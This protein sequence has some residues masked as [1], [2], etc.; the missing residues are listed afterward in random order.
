MTFRRIVTTAIAATLSLSALP[1]FAQSGKHGNVIII[2]Q[3][4]H[5][6]RDNRSDRRND[7]QDR[8]D[9]RR[10]DRQDRR[11][12]RR[13]DRAERRED[14]RDDRREQRYQRDHHR[15]PSYYYSARGSEFRRGH[16]LPSA[17][18]SPQYVVVNY[19]RH[20]LKAPP[21]GHQWVQV[22]AD[23]VLVAV[24]TGLI[25]HILLSH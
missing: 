22:G 11:D 8:R 24:A 1:S 5:D 2:Q 9:D 18:R 3:D 20:H 19:Q 25:A 10:D 6:R 15:A 12:D 16:R 7:R 14:R 13:E 21:R 23:Y 4:Q 17:L